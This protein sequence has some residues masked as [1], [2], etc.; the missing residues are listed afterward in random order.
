[1][2][3]MLDKDLLEH[4]KNKRCLCCFCADLKK[5]VLQDGLEAIDNY[6]GMIC[7]AVKDMFVRR[8]RW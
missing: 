1:M 5:Q 8:G 4:I 6:E 3:K 2:K 7:G